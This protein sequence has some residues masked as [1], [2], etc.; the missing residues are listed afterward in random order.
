MQLERRIARRDRAILRL[1]SGGKLSRGVYRLRQ[2]TTASGEPLFE[3]AVD[4]HVGLREQIGLNDLNPE[5]YLRYV[6]QRIADHPINRV[7]ELPPWNVV[8]QLQ[9]LKLAA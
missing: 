3:D 7:D 4:S 9:Q 8:A 5:A 1:A 2:T 6:L